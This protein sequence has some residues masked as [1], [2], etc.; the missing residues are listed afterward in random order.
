MKTALKNHAIS[1]K[2][3]QKKLN[4]KKSVSVDWEEIHD[5]LNELG[6]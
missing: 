3:L 6:Y 4:S 1:S 5:L 2:R